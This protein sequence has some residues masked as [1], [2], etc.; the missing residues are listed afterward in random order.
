MIREILILSVCLLNTGALAGPSTSP[1]Y[2]GKAGLIPDKKFE[3]FYTKKVDQAWTV[4][5]INYL[6]DGNVYPKGP[7]CALENRYGDGS[8]LQLSVPIR[9]GR[10]PPPFKLYFKDNTWE[11]SGPFPQQASLQL[12]MFKGGKFVDGGELKFTV[13]SKNS[14]LI[15]GIAGKFG[16]S[17]EKSDKLVFVMPGTIRNSTVTLPNTKLALLYFVECDGAY[18]DLPEEDDMAEPAN[19]Q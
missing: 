4:Y 3:T 6:V 19:R 9:E 16:M 12:N 18:S 15:N 5:G 14:I 8:L 11:I 13:M 7:I 10:K 2:E 17:L 1:R